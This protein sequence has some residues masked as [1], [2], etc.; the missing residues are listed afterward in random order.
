MVSGLQLRNLHFVLRDITPPLEPTEL[1]TLDGEPLRPDARGDEQADAAPQDQPTTRVP[2]EALNP[3]SLTLAER[4]LE[5]IDVR[6]FVDR[7]L[8]SIPSL[9]HVMVS[10]GRPRRCG[11]VV[12]SACCGKNDKA[13]MQVYTGGEIKYKEMEE[14]EL[15]QKTPDRGPTWASMSRAWYQ[16]AMTSVRREEG[17]FGVAGGADVV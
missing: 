6:D 3:A 5:A 15:T 10:V 7:L 16:G 12:R 13:E 17:R 2:T 11:G 4:T 14:T 8:T 9:E 1:P